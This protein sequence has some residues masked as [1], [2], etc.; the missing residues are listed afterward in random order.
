MPAQLAEYD[1]MQ[2]IAW[3][4]QSTD[5]AM[6][7]ASM[8]LQAVGPNPTDRGKNGGKRHLLVDGLVPGASRLVSSR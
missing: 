1:Q 6:F 3:R 8:A 5:G 2:G 7:K 4:W